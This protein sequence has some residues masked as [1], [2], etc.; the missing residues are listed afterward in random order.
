MSHVAPAKDRGGWRVSVVDL[1]SNEVASDLFRA[2]IVCNG[3]YSIPAFADVANLRQFGGK[4]R[5]CYKQ[6]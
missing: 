3:H 2:V 1:A 5:S 4:V 6:S